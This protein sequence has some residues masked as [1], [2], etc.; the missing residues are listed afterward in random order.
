MKY[1][2][3]L[4]QCPSCQRRLFICLERKPLEGVFWL[5][6]ITG[7]LHWPCQCGRIFIV[8]VPRLWLI[9][10]IIVAVTLAIGWFGILLQDNPQIPAAISII[11]TFVLPIVFIYSAS[12]L[13][14]C[15]S[16]DENS[17]P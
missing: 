5:Y 14:K 11:V 3:N 1:L 7:N 10:I 13:V 15:L 2:S 9:S 4:S 12:L 6:R 16:D 17:S 8:P